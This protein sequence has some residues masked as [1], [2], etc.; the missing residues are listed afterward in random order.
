MSTV[1]SHLIRLTLIVAHII[2]S[3]LAGVRRIASSIKE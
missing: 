3:T 1:K 2:E